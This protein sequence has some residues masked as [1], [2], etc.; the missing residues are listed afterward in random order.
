M[1]FYIY[2]ILGEK[3]GATKDWETRRQAN[4]N[5][6]SIEP[7]LIE[8]MEGP[9]DEDMWQLVGDREWYYADING[10]DRGTHYRTARLQRIEM[11]RRGAAAG[12]AAGRGIPNRHLRSLTIEQVNEIK[13]KYVRGV[14]GVLKLSKEYDV[15][16]ATISNIINNKFYTTP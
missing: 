5:K 7:I 4:F 2:E 9:D 11:N 15:S 12:G 8:T 3:N 1:V 10:Y 16:G 13:S 6:Y 14:Y